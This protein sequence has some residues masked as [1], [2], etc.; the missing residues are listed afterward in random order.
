MTIGEAISSVFSGAGRSSDDFP[1]RRRFVYR[2]LKFARNELI[3]QELNKGNLYDE[4]SSQTIECLK[5]ERVDAS[6]CFR[7]DSGIYILRSV[8]E[9]PD[10][11][12]CDSGPAITGLYMQNGAIINPL[13]FD[14]WQFRKER[15]NRLPGAFGYALRNRHL[16]LL[17]YDDV[18]EIDVVFSAHFTSPEDIDKINSE[19]EDCPKD[20]KCK[21]IADMDFHCPGHL[22]RRVIEITRA[23][24]FR[25]LGI[26]E[27]NN[28]NAKSD[29]YVPRPQVVNQ[30]RSV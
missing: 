6:S 29:T 2:E 13:S 20:A 25:K 22:E 4:F 19:R 26:P 17:D 27:D 14:D 18:D 3:K 9:L 12:Q 5:L 28:N 24:I 8:N 16:F 21:S 10:I 1:I 11:I 7:C 15:R 30:Q 23:V